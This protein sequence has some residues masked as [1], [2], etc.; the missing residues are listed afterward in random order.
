MMAPS[1]I[2]STQKAKCL[3]YRNGKR[4]GRVAHY[5]VIVLDRAIGQGGSSTHL[6]VCDN[7]LDTLRADRTRYA[8]LTITQAAPHGFRVRS[9]RTFGPVSREYV[10]VGERNE[11]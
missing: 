4:C 11:L 6:V 7:C 2:T 1:L 9:E 5:E 3:K 10:A 8:K